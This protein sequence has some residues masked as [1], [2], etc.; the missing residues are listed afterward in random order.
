[1]PTIWSLEMSCPVAE[2]VSQEIESHSFAYLNV[3]GKLQLPN[4][5]FGYI[6]CHTSTCAI[7][8]LSGDRHVSVKEFVRV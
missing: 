5:V 4:P 3:S 8:I 1:M 7:F 2:L 6:C